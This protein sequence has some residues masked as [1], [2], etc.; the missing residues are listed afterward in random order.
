MPTT[1]ILVRD[2]ITPGDRDPDG[3]HND[4]QD[5]LENALWQELPV[6][7]TAGGTISVVLSDVQN[8]GRFLLTGT[9]GG[10]FNL[11]FAVVHRDLIVQNNSGQTATIQ[12]VG[13]TD[14]V[15]L[16]D[17]DQI[18]VTIETDGDVHIVG[19]VGGGAGTYLALSDT[20]ASFSGE[21]GKIPQVNLDET[22]IEFGDGAAIALKARYR[23]SVARNAAD[24]TAQDYSGSGGDV[25]TW[26]TDVIDTDSI[27]DVGSD[28]SRMT[29]PTGVTKIRLHASIRVEAFT[30][31]ND[32]TAQFSKNGSTLIGTGVYELRET[33]NSE[34]IQDMHSEVLI[35]VA[36]DY[37][38]VN[39]DTESDTDVTVATESRFELEIVEFEGAVD[40]PLAYIATSPKFKGA[41]IR[42]NSAQSLTA[43]ADSV[44][45]FDTLI[46]DTRF[47]PG[48]TGGP[49]RFWLGL[50]FDFVDGD[51]TVGT[52]TIAETDHDFETG[53]GP[54][55]LTTSGTLP[56]GLTTATDYWAIRVDADN[57]KPAVSRA[58]AIAGTA[59][60]ITAAAGGGTHTVD[61]QDFLVI[62][63]G[64]SKVIL[65]GHLDLNNTTGD[66]LWRLQKEGSSFLGGW[67]VDNSSTGGLD[68][69]E[70]VSSVI[71]VSEGDRFNCMTNPGPGTGITTTASSNYVWFQ[72]EVVETTLP[73]DFPGVT[74]HPKFKGALVVL[75]SDETAV[76]T[77]SGH[78]SAWDTE[79]Y[80][81]DNFHDN[82]VNPS[83][84]TI[85]AGLGITKIRLTGTYGL[86]L[87]DGDVANLTR[88]FKNGAT[89]AELQGFRTQVS[90]SNDPVNNITSPVIEVVDGDYFEIETRGS[91]DISITILATRSHFAIEVVETIEATLPP[92]DY[93][94]F[95]EGVPT[96]S[97]LAWATIAARRVS[98]LDNFAGSVAECITAPS[99]EVIFDIDVEGTKIGDITFAASATVG[100]FDTTGATQEDVEIGERL[101]IDTPSDLFTGADF[102][103]TLKGFRT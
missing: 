72:I 56:A 83:R 73:L 87:Q 74:V 60:D 7:T 89:V 68:L 31:T 54:F 23:G 91:A 25:I 33:G 29:V 4:G 17:G 50:D 18:S 81:T 19:G 42:R 16:A 35:V 26:D 32:A 80:D 70:G 1:P 58:A 12:A 100:T 40:A 39:M 99:S 95:L 41:G 69:I 88:F 64:V 76:D 37:F 20:P 9:P 28:T 45:N 96:V 92:N 2:H 62:P 78:F 8:F 84:L 24:L 90:S 66:I 71:S 75:G 38:E 102:M 63:A 3:V 10:A 11:E 15:D 55:R 49:Q 27:H 85:P 67:N 34:F 5:E 59:V 57:F 14:T 52:D 103:I 53:E 36:A 51:V 98:F 97:N 77:T 82:S 65:R 43:S 13:G 21:A 30:T 61:R 79:R 47:N 6:V 48:D 44:I 93:P 94:I 22:A 46:S 86:S 101:S